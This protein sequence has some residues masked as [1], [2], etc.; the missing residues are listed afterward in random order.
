MKR[1]YIYFLLIL[2]LL[3]LA[4]MLPF[5]YREL[6]DGSR[7]IRN[8][9]DDDFTWIVYTI[10]T[11]TA[12]ILLLIKNRFTALFGTLIY[13]L[14]LGLSIFMNI[15]LLD[16]RPYRKIGVGPTL[17]FIVMLVAV[18]FG[19]IHTRKLF[20]NRTQKAKANSDLLDDA[21]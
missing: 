7:S 15:V 9:F 16:V 1:Y 11:L 14:S 19:V 4:F 6:S 20:K 12:T 3:F 18:I 21:F 5:T 2:P 17:I 13:M 10:P 8:S